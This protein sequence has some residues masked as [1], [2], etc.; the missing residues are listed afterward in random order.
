MLQLPTVAALCLSGAAVVS[1]AS[2]GGETD[3][4]T[5]SLEP[6]HGLRCAVVT[7]DLG[8]S[9]EIS[10][11]VT[12]DKAVRGDYA[13]KIRNASGGGHAIIDQSGEFSVDPG[14][15]TTLGQATLGGVS[16]SYQ[17]EL[18]LTIN[19]QRLRCLGAGTHTD[20]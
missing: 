17:A 5:V 8:D 20:I 4:R 16:G 15:T 2:F 7:R 19:G 9:V 1:L 6:V 14:R 18:E 13:L 3:A 10:G 11:K 12:S